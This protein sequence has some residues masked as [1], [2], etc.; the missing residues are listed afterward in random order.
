MDKPFQRIGSKSNTHVGREF[1]SSAS[2]F[3]LSQGIALVPNLKVEVGVSNLKKQH[4]FDLGCVDQKIIVECKAHKWTKGGNVPSAKLTV[5]NEAMYYFYTSP[6]S[7]RKIMFVLRDFS[8]KRN[9]TLA[10]YYIRTY[11]HLIPNDVE[12]WEYNENTEHASKL[13]RPSV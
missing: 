4:A 1:E 6:A 7:F 10:Q 9:E 11:K 8:E 13:S 12:L 5:W 3:F 2:K